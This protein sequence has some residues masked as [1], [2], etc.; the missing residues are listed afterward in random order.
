MVDDESHF[1][2]QA[3]RPQS[4]LVTVPGDDEQ[5]SV[6]RRGHHFPLRAALASYSVTRAAEP[7]GRGVEQFGR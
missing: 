1:L 4:G 6:R 3:L 7:A 5:V 2:A